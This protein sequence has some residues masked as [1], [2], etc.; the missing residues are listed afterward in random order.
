VDYVEDYNAIL[1]DHHRESSLLCV[2]NCEHQK[3]TATGATAIAKSLGL[4]AY[5]RLW[6]QDAFELRLN[7]SS[8][9]VLWCDF[10]VGA[11]TK[12]FVEASWDSLRP[13]GFLLCHS[14]LT[15]RQTR[16]WLEAVRARQG[17][18]VTGLPP[19]EYVEVS[20][21]E[22]HKQYQNSIT[23][24]QKRDRYTEPLYSLKA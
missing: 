3:E 8:I 9:D 6:K 14:T 7:S 20:L 2:D 23:I 16:S 22:P 17:A 15:N 13:G 4:D 24:L 21:L 12:E 18:D 19:N 5:L 10:G 1:D 11:R